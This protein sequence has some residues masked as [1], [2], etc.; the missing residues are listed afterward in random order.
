MHNEIKE[1]TET[2]GHRTIVR[3]DGGEEV[4]QSKHKNASRNEYTTR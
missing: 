2:K 3:T 4:Q 1:K